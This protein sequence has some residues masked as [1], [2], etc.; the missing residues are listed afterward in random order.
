MVVQ[1]LGRHLKIR[2]TRLP[3]DSQ[4][5]DFTCRVKVPYHSTQDLQRLHIYRERKYNYLESTPIHIN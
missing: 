1:S 3:T 5:H 4:N 2:G